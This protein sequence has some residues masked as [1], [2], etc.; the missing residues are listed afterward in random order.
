MVEKGKY[1]C[2]L[3]YKLGREKTAQILNEVDSRAT[4]EKRMWSLKRSMLKNEAK[5]EKGFSEMEKFVSR[6]RAAKLTADEI[7]RQ[8]LAKEVTW[9]SPCHI[10]FQ[11]GKYRFCHDARASTRGFCLNEYLIG[12]LNLMTPLL[13]P[14]NNLRRYLFAFSCDILIR[15]EHLINNTQFPKNPL[16]LLQLA[17]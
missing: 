10:V 14:V 3:P 7:K 2:G 17:Q 11:K 1:S 12:D 13:D 16:C 6:E 9:Y 8:D 5:M 15:L 4:A